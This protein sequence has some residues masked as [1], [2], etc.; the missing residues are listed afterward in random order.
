MNSHTPA[1]A[2]V[3]PKDTF[4]ERD[5]LLVWESPAISQGSEDS[6]RLIEAKVLIELGAVPEKWTENAVGAMSSI[7]R[8]VPDI[9]ILH[10][11]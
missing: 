7:H 6:I 4:R 8:P 1:L 3:E 9:M 10:A 2:S 11:I 5:E